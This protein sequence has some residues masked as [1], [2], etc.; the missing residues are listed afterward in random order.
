MSKDPLS[1]VNL[2]KSTKRTRRKYHI[3]IPD[4]PKNV[5]GRPCKLNDALSFQ[6]LQAIEAGMTITR[7]C[8]LCG[9]SPIS[10]NSYLESGRREAT[11]IS[12]AIFEKKKEL[13]SNNQWPSDQEVRECLIE[14]FIQELKPSKFFNFLIS[15]EKAKATCE[16]KCLAAIISAIKGSEYLSEQIIEKTALGKVK[17]VTEKKSYLKPDWRAARW[18]LSKINAETYGDRQTV[19]HEGQDIQTIEHEHTITIDESPDRLAGVLQ[20]LIECGAFQNKLIENVTDTNGSSL[21]TDS[22][23]EKE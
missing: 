1:T 6:I 5:A 13:K 18:L 2:I 21:I 7:A 19:E 12:Q 23:F 4:K 16:E 14:D 10:Y 8:Q 11:R 15:I 20:I 3:G 22:N 9:I 17:S